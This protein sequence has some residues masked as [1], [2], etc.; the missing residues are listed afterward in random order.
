MATVQK[1]VLAAFYA[2]LSKSKEFDQPMIDALRGLLESN[3][4]VKADDIVALLAKG[5]QEGGL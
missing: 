2:T 4:K 1:D 5:N 3:K